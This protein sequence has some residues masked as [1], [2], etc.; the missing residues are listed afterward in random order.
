MK[1]VYLVILLVL[2]TFMFGCECNHEWTEASCQGPGEC[3]KC[4]ETTGKRLKHSWIEATCEIEKH[5]EMCGKTE[6]VALG[7]LWENATCT[8]AKEC[9]VCHEIEGE[10]L[11]HEWEEATCTTPKKCSV[12]G[13]TDG[14]TIAHKGSESSEWDIDY[15][16]ATKVQKYC[17]TVCKEIIEIQSERVTTFVN[18]NQFVIYPAAFASRFEDSSSR[19][20]NI[21]YY[22]KSET[23]YDSYIYDEDN[24]IFYRI[25]DENDDY[26]DIG[27]ISFSDE[28]HKT[29]SVI[30]NYSENSIVNINILIEDSYDVSAVVYSAILA[31]DPGIGY[32]EAADVGQEIVDNIAIE[33]GDIDEAVFK[34]I[35]Y[36]GI[37][38]LLYKDR[39][40]HYLIITTKR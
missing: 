21:D 9:S 23:A 3:V 11:G 13:E 10:A 35:T 2:V 18:G 15:D 4:G 16:N 37:N 14:E 25:Q 19:L 39:E 38:Y 24:S 5:C 1:K 20:N 6:G 31:I 26:N 30:D 8:K 36:N 34:G 29:L 32:S 27:M 7:H 33:V 40:Y 12:C 28:K 22:T 17:C